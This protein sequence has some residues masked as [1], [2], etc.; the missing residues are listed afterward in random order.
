MNYTSIPEVYQIEVTSACNLDCWMC[1]RK[2]F[3][4]KLNEFIDVD[5]VK[6]IAERD[7][8]GSYFVELQLIGEPL[9]HPKLDEIIDILKT[10]VLVGMST[11]GQLL[12]IHLPTVCKLDYLTISVD[13]LSKYESI[14]KGGSLKRLLDN[15]DLLMQQPIH[16]KTD[17]QIIELPG[18]EDEYKALVQMSKDKNWDCVIRAVQ[19]CEKVVRGENERE[20]L[21]KDD[22]CMNP[23]MSVSIHAGGDVVPC[24]FAWGKDLV[25]GNLNEKN[26]EDIWKG[27]EVKALRHC[28]RYQKHLPTYCR[29]CYARSPTLFHLQMLRGHFRK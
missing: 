2:E 29:N 24:C 13:S 20:D 21:V 26:L 19:D 12:H 22:L 5:L 3:G 25:Y 6:K 8:G 27:E 9:L 4:R 16:P 23:F 1:P 15:I 7:L 11:N 10:K 18:W 28:H 17:L 14:R